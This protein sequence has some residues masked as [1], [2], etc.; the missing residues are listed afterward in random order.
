LRRKRVEG[1]V[2]IH[3]WQSRAELRDYTSFTIIVVLKRKCRH[4]CGKVVIKSEFDA[5]IIEI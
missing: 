3:E 4:D 2:Y 1:R 5:T